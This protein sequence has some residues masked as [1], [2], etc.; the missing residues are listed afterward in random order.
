MLEHQK[1]KK[2]RCDGLQSHLPLWNPGVSASTKKSETPCAARFPSP[3]VNNRIHNPTTY[4][5]I[6]RRTSFSSR[7]Q[8]VQST[9]SVAVKSVAVRLQRWYIIIPSSDQWC[10]TIK[11]HRYQWLSYPKTIGKSLIS[12]VARNHSI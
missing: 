6:I 1:R 10:T 8:S 9:Y 5:I 12:M 3:G 2:V 11:N 7:I 4:D